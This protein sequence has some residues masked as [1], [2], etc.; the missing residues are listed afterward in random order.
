[1]TSEDDRS[2][3]ELA[4]EYLSVLD[5]G[6][7]RETLAEAEEEATELRER[8]ERFAEKYG[9]SDPAT[10]EL[11]DELSSAEEKVE[12]L[13]EQQSLPAELEE[14]L[15]ERAT[16]FMLTEEWLQTEIIEA[17]NQALIDEHDTSLVIEEIEIASKEDVDG[18]DEPTKFDVI[19]IVRQLA[20][21]K[22]GRL[23]DI[24]D[25]WETLEG[26]TKEEPFRIVADVGGATPDD[27]LERIEADEVKRETVRGRLKNATQKDINPYLRREGVY[28]LSTVGKYIT[29]EY[30]DVAVLDEEE[31][32]TSDDE[33]EDEQATLDQKPLAEDGD[34]D[35]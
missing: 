7:D 31:G 18:L 28:H 29:L 8:Y 15:L 14:E 16:S 33:A 11:A 24:R 2:V 12:Q 10:R 30:A 9:E 32:A 21:D 20:L 4:D 1:M 25:C 26:T 34:S 23:S 3:G 19:D 17:L 35:E 22:L 27:V 6:P 5:E 13:K